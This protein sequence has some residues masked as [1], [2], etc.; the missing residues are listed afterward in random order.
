MFRSLYV[1]PIIAALLL[2]ACA[3]YNAAPANPHPPV[4]TP[5]VIS[6]AKNGSIK[7]NG[8]HVRL[9]DLPA[10][11]KA[12]GVTSKSKLTIEGDPDASQQ[13]IDRV[14]ESLVDNGLLPKGTI[15]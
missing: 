10:S 14:L 2:S 1:F 5:P 15:D 12:M 9:E 4:K 11:L 7:L 3:A 8:T 6:V 13:D